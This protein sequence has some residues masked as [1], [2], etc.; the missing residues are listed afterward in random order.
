[1]NTP[2]TLRVSHRRQ[3][4]GQDDLLLVPTVYRSVLIGLTHRIERNRQTGLA[5]FDSARIQ[6]DDP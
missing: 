5:P 4:D 1:M 3:P 6:L 2:S